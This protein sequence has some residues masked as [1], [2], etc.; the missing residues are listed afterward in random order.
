MLTGYE[1]FSAP[2][3]LHQFFNNNQE[4]LLNY[5]N[6]LPEKNK[7][8]FIVYQSHRLQCLN[9]AYLS[10]CDEKLFELITGESIVPTTQT[11]IFQVSTSEVRK[12]VLQR[13]GQAQFST[14]V[15]NNYNS[16]CCFPGC[17]INDHAFLIGSHI[18]RWVDNFEKRGEIANGLCLCAFH[19]KAFEAGYFSLDDEYEIIPSEKVAIIQSDVYQTLILP[20]AGKQITLGAIKP[21]HDSLR[22]HRFRCGIHDE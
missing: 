22:E 10:A 16:Q 6:S 13:R 4:S 14:A 11:A 17:K 2:I 5:L 9:G 3:N 18:A 21:D 20:Y 7:N 8:C 15:K 1:N 12:A 19:D